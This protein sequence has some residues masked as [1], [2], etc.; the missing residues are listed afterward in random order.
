MKRSLF[1]SH[2]KEDQMWARDDLQGSRWSPKPKYSN[3]P[4]EAV[5]SHIPSRGMREE[6]A[7]SLDLKDPS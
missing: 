4:G 1:L 3:T 2:I 7:G 6:K 5:I